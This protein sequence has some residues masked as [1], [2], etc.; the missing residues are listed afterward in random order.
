MDFDPNE[1]TTRPPGT[2]PTGVADTSPSKSGRYLAIGIAV[3][4]VLAVAY[5]LVKG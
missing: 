4:I 3:A 5:W 2:P 1:P